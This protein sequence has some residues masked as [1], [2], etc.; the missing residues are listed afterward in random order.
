MAR[1]QR[2]NP[3]EIDLNDLAGEWQ[4]QPGY[5]RDAGV[6][7][8]DARAKHTHAKMLLAVTDAR[9]YLEIRNNP[10]ASGLRRKPTKDEIEAAVTIH[11]EHC[12]AQLAVNEAQYEWD[13]AKA[14]TTAFIDRRKALENEVELLALDYRNATEPRPLSEQ[15]Q[16]VL[17]RRRSRNAF[18]D[19][20]DKDGE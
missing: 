20:V 15:A 11:Q 1:T 18:G 19:G 7:E 2:T 5:A 6:R 9:L 13:I 4:V 3:F 12:N 17:N 16:N 8:A 10:E 14:D